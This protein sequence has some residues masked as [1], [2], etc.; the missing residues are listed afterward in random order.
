[1]R[2][3]L[4]FALTLAFVTEALSIFKLISALS[5]AICWS[6][7]TMAGIIYLAGKRE[8][9]LQFTGGLKAQLRQ[10]YRQ[11]TLFERL[12]VGA[13][14]VLFLL[15][16]VQGLI[17]PPNNFDSLTYHLSRIVSWIS[18]HS[19]APY[20]TYIPRQLY[21]PPLAEYFILNLN[22]LSHSDYFSATV[23]FS[24]QLFCLVA[25][26]AIARQLGLNRFQQV[27]AF[28][29]SATI[30]EVVLQST[31]TQNDLVVSFFVLSAFYFCIRSIK[32]QH[33]SSYLFLGLSTGLGIF[34]KGTAYIF[35]A[36][37]LILFGIAVLKE[38][39]STKQ[40]K[41]LGFAVAMVA[42]LPLLINVS[43]YH[44]NYSYSGNMLGVD[45]HESSLYG[46]TRMNPKLFICNTAKNIDLNM[47]FL[48]VPRI[49]YGAGKVVHKIFN[50]TGVNINE[51]T[52][53]YP[54]T[55]LSGIPGDQTY[56][57]G[58]MV[59]T[60]EDYGSNFISLILIWISLCIIAWGYIEKRIGSTV[61]TLLVVT[62]IVEGI[63]F[64]GYLKWQPWGTRLQ[65]PMFLLSTPLICCATVL[66]KWFTKVVKVLVPLLVAYA[67]ILVIFNFIRPLIS[68]PKVFHGFLITSRGNVFYPRSMKLFFEDGAPSAGPEYNAINADIKK[69]NYK[70]LGLILPDEGREY[71]LFEDCYTR[72]LNPVH[73]LVTNYTKNNTGYND[74]VE[75]ILSTTMHQPFIDYKGKRFFNQNPKNLTIWYYKL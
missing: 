74:D 69:S 42:L 10:T 34:T 37:I 14:G 23:Q 20:P 39:F 44:R 59:A 71:P 18:H 21:Q 64:C 41:K 48:C 47:G 11:F 15:E 68:V 8:Q 12:L 46:V 50:S 49:T 56:F 5:V 24:F 65:T 19:V 28:V 55:Q 6:V 36:P 7:I 43:Q 29:L 73:I 2:T 22:L 33:T 62:V 38:T 16:F 57:S 52:I 31:S 58:L 72:E 4:A 1:M 26:V 54:F 3:V 40:Y 60:E 30:P 9:L 45:Q 61:T 32:G 63:L 13:I 17:Y 25:I 35:I 51:P 70:N 75:C 67:F 66:S 53:T 27:M